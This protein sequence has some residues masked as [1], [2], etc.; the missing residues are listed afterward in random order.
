MDNSGS[1][2]PNDQKMVDYFIENK[3]KVLVASTPDNTE[4]EIK[5]T[6]GQQSAVD[7]A[8]TR[9]C[10]IPEQ[11]GAD[12][13]DRTTWASKISST[14]DASNVSCENKKDAT[15]EEILHV[16]SDAASVLYPNIWG[17]NEGE[18]LDKIVH[19]QIIKD[20]GSATYNNYK[21][22]SSGTCSGK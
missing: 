14:T 3:T 19:E 20:C 1:G 21:N 13:T 4:K 10:G 6:N 16:L 15:V 8:S 18:N 17:T 7:E 12:S 2:S 9:S 5:D 22:P 11:R